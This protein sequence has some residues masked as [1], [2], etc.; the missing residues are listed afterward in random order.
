MTGQQPIQRIEVGGVSLVS[1]ER[2]NQIIDRLNDISQARVAP[3]AGVGKFVSAAGSFILDLSQLDER[4]RA[5]EAGDGSLVWNAVY[6]TAGALGSNTLVVANTVYA[7]FRQVNGNAWLD[8][9]ALHNTLTAINSR[10]TNLIASINN[11]SISANCNAN[12][13]AITV[14]LTFPNVPGV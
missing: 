6:N 12:S 13:N 1:A 2:A 5:V 3:I 7:N 4:V 14:T 8:F 10:L 11:S 9:S